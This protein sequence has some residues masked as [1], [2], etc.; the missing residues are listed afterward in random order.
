MKI[1]QQRARALRKRVNEL[2]AQLRTMRSNWREDWPSGI[3]I[4]AANKGDVIAEEDL[5][6]VR[7]ARRLGHAVIVTEHDHCLHFY[8]EK[9]P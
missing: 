1:S 9:L 2:E 4:L 3:H 8:A 5:V 7:T 6:A